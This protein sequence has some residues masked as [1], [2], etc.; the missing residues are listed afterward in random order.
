M[1]PT[2]LPARSVN[3]Q[4]PGHAAGDV[5]AGAGAGRRSIALYPALLAAVLVVELVNVSGVSPFSAGRP[6]IVALLVALLLAWI[7]RVLLGDEA[8]GGVFAALWVLTLL[9][10]DDPRLAL[11]VVAAS[12]LLLA[13]RYLLPSGRRTIRWPRISGFL[14]KL[15]AVFA[16]AVVIQSIQTG[17]LA[18]AAR[19]ATHETPLR[20]A[21][22][23]ATPDSPDPDIYMI[24]VDGHARA[25]VISSVFG[26]DGSVL[27]RALETDG[28][29][30]TPRSRSNYTQTGETLSSM[31]SQA[32][33]RD[34]PRMADLLAQTE[35]HPP[36]GIVRNVINDN[37]TWTF[38]RDRGY[39]IDS[40]SS[41]F[42][43]VAIREAD[44]FEDTGQ[45]NELEL[46]VLQR[47]VLGRLLEALA[48]DAVSGQQRDR[49]Q[50]VFDAFA[51]APSW[52]GDGPQFVFAHVPSPHPPWVFNAD[53][54]PRTVSFHQ[55]WLGETPATTGLSVPELKLGYAGQ[56]ADADRRLLET[57]PKLDAA[58]AARGRPA[59]VIVFSDHGSWIGAD[60]GDI[61][62][63]F[64]NLLAIWS[65]DGKVSV[66]PNLTLVNL[67]PSIFEQLYGVEWVHR[68]D[69]QYRFGTT[70][71]FELLS[72][73][74]PDAA[75]SP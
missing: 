13:E 9:G 20:A 68:L 34:V 25:D 7:G 5:G 27:T 12:A 33:L 53:G 54:S 56:V 62:L 30:V 31:F 26:A 42:E 46:A 39:E 55:Q 59:V 24:L 4:H 36:G 66:E 72:V 8:R 67:F 70:S 3:D 74:D 52:I 15:V 44:R 28:F 37:A 49:I 19:S 48:P 11:T 43:Q 60:G 51:T 1:T 32:Q 38:L 50:G 10:G 23:K 65:T 41:G 2:P 35:D 14:S 57:L 73:D 18:D 21:F 22:A 75:A 29:A 17:A 63:R 6:M 47:S 45:L 40:V 58:I 69:T 71:A 64:K 61:R 16:L